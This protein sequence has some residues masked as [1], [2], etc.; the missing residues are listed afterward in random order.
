DNAMARNKNHMS[1]DARYVGLVDA[2]N[3]TTNVMFFADS[4]G[5]LQNDRESLLRMLASELISGVGPYSV[6]TK[7]AEGGLAYGS[8]LS[9]NVK[10]RLLTFYAAKSPEVASLLRL[11]NSVV[12]TVPQIRDERFID[13]A[14]QN[15]FPIP[16]SMFT[17]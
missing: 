9:S 17:F 7:T 2:R 10:F 13:Y 4:T 15:A 1:I 11:V 3:S 16:R 14:Y 6:Y 5:Y 8:S 12:E